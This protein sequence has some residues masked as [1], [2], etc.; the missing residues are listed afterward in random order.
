MKKTVLKQL[1]SRWAILSIETVQIQKAVM[2]DSAMI[3]E[4][5]ETM[6]PDNDQIDLIPENSDSDTDI[7][8]TYD[9]QQVPPEKKTEKK[10]PGRPK[11]DKAD[12]AVENDKTEDSPIIPETGNP[13][14]K[15]ESG[16]QDKGG[17]NS[18]EDY[19][20]NAYNK[21]PDEEKVAIIDQHTKHNPK[22]EFDYKWCVEYHNDNIK[23]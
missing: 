19:W 10:K 16:T 1:L 15:Q 9:I 18:D 3:D 5:G 20:I 23:F 13:K 8:E 11:K 17:G 4:N 14:T 2:N 21:I 7:N 12:K 6:Y 22:G